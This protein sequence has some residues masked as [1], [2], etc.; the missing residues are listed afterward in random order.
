MAL[1]NIKV[2]GLT[3]LK[4]SSVSWETYPKLI[5][6]LREAKLI[7][8]QFVSSGTHW[9]PC[10]YNGKVA[11]VYREIGLDIQHKAEDF[12]LVWEEV[13]TPKT[14]SLPTSLTVLTQRT[15]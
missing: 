11:G 6:F 3:W 13:L 12:W 1:R 10:Y 5:R 14:L 4:S 15:G 8:E 9:H 7:P 2:K